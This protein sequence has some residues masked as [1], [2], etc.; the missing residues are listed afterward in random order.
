MKKIKKEDKE[1]LKIQ[2]E[3]KKQ[4][5]ILYKYKDVVERELTKGQIHTLLEYNRQQVPSGKSNVISPFVFS[6]PISLILEIF[7]VLSFTGFGSF[8]RHYDLWITEALH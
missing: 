7:P 5:K 8:M 2:E 4:N 6:V 1:D 3:I